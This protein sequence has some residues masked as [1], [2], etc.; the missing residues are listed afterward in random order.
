MALILTAQR[1]SRVTRLALLATNTFVDTPIPPPLSMVTWPLL[2][3]LSPQRFRPCV[4]CRVAVGRT[5]CRSP[6]SR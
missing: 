1:S 4:N 5:W 2:G 3:P 6:S